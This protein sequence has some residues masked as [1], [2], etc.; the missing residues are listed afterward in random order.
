[1]TQRMITLHGYLIKFQKTIFLPV[2]N[3]YKI[4]YHITVAI[5][6]SDSVTARV[7]VCLFL[8]SAFEEVVI[9]SV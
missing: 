3:T 4:I 5:A 6:W 8:L 1:M 7:C 9:L 2:S